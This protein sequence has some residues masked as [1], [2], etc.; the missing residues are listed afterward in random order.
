MKLKIEN[1]S[2]ELEIIF[3]MENLELKDNN[4]KDKLNKWL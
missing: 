4:R 1:F 2:Q 3:Q